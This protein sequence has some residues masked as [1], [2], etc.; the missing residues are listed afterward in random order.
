MNR[1]PR[2]TI[3]ALLGLVAYCAA[4]F[5]VMRTSSPYL[6]SAMVSLTVLALLGSAVAGIWGRHRAL[7]GWGYFLI[8]F[9]SPFRDVVSPHLMTSVAI[10][11]S[12]RYLHPE[13][14]IEVTDLAQLPGAG[15]P[16]GPPILNAVRQE[17]MPASQF[18]A[19]ARGGPLPIIRIGLPAGGSYSYVPSGR[20]RF[21]TYECSAHAAFTLAFAGFGGLFATMV[22]CRA[23]RTSGE[24]RA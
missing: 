3:A 5:A 15:M 4:T 20:N 16:I 17:H 21:Y 9:T 18:V 11:E 1:P 8:T 19:V 24:R 23:A 2:L 10:V 12:Y 6:A 7:F 14:N 22:A 13:V